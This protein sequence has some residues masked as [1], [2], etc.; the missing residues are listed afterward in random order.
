MDISD[1]R[2]GI[3][4]SDIDGDA[5]PVVV[6]SSVCVESDH[7]TPLRKRDRAWYSGTPEVISQTHDTNGIDTPPLSAWFPD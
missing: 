1:S 4:S 3:P 6:P 7:A 2:A 5:E